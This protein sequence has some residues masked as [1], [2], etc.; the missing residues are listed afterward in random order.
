MTDTSFQVIHDQASSDV[1]DYDKRNFL[2][3]E[4]QK[5]IWVDKVN[6]A[7]VDGRMCGW[8]TTLH[9]DKLPCQLVGGFLHGSYNLCQ[10]FLFTDNATLLLRFPRVGA[11][12]EDYADEK[13]AI[14]VEVL[15][16]IR[17]RT[18]IPVP[19]VYSWGPA[20]DNPLGLGAFILMEFI[21]GTSLNR[22]LRDPN[23]AVDTRLMREDISDTDVEF[24]LSQI[25]R[26]QLQLFELDF[27]RI[28]SLPTQK[29]SFSAP[30]RP[31]TWKV[32]DIIQT[33]GVNTFGMRQSSVPF[34]VSK[35]IK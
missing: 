35:M 29:T 16:V 3:Q 30:I 25:S 6:A 19:E 18:S 8:V 2:F 10:K 4:V 12:S 22:L 21:E 5:D 32:H 26:F 1:M 13:I 27:D 28:G 11:I 7:R 14:E 17:E 24:L 31:L 23:A 9:P 15:S 33:G 20:S 34:T